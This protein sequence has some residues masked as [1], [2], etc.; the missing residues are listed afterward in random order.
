VKF[1]FRSLSRNIGF[2]SVSVFSL[3]VGIGLFAA[4][5]AFV[6][7]TWLSPVPGVEGA[8][9][10]AELTTLS[11]G[12]ESEAWAYP[13]FLDLRATETPFRDIAGWKDR[14]GTLYTP[15]GGEYVRM[16][17]VSAN[18]FRL[19]GVTPARGR[20]F[21]TSE[22]AGP[23]QNPVALVS[24][25]MWR[26]RLS[27]DPEII[28]RTLVLNQQP[29]T[30]VGI[31]PEEFT[32]HRTLTQETEIWVPLTQDPWVA[33]SD[34]WVEDRASLWLRVLGRLREG[35]TLEEGNAALGTIFSRLAEDHPETNRGRG[36]RA[37][38]FGPVPAVGRSDSIF[39]TLLLAGLLGLVLLIICGNVAGMVLARSVTREREI[40]VRL[41]LGAGRGRLARLLLVEALFLSVAG[42]VG[43][44]FL[45][46]WGMEAAYA[47]IPG[48]PR[49]SFPV[50][51]HLLPSMAGL[52]LG[53]ALLVGILPALRFSRPELVSSLKEGAGGSG[54]RVGRVHRFAA[55]AQTGLA[56]SLLVVS[57]LFVRAVGALGEKELGFEPEGLL[58]TRLDLSGVGIETQ[59]MAEVY[60]DRIRSSLGTVPGITAVAVADGLPVDL[61][62]NFTSVSRLDRPDDSSGR[63][64]VEFTRVGEGYFETIGTP[65]LRGRGIEAADGAGSETVIILTQ[66]LADR[67]FP[68]EEAIGQRV[69]SGASRNGPAEFTVVGIVQDVASSR[70]TE[71]WP[72]VF[73]SMKQD[74]YP[75]A[76]LVM[77]G[78]SD[79]AGLYRPVREALLGADPNLPHP[80]VVSSETLLDQAANG[81]KTSAGVAGGLGVLAILLAAIGVYGVVAFTVSRRTREIGLRMAMGASRGLVLLE[82]LRDGVRL[83]AP[84]LLVGAILS[85][86]A[87]TAFR[88]KLFGLSPLDP[89]SFL[90]AGFV[91]FLIILLASIP[92]ALRASGID[93]MEA[94]RSE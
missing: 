19:L 50:G 34:S 69:A 79:P 92:P 91:L 60:L 27:G 5:A 31:A 54:R 41:A 13:D 40:A 59:E 1:A 35:A 78:P 9:E 14:D 12:S 94:L 88:A 24:H 76:M 73:F 23:G 58:T 70:P 15:E 89:A 48:A 36:A 49:L 39:A 52:V 38:R 83:A 28:G 68:G 55:S 2:T 74:Y 56:L 51:W 81:Q 77:R 29:H 44:V 75:R 3:A 72:N 90:G 62:G 42:G 63:V 10:V 85:G 86:G 7:E 82:V 32:G 66:T 64:Q 4:F 33:G 18:Y 46:V 61:V 87:A 30:V 67:L 21:L 71:S 57:G 22:D 8:Q 25:R 11:R 17:S 43:G 84:G 20:D 80:V 65:I 45:G 53:T 37:H 6:Q 16:M 47:L 93:P 26:D